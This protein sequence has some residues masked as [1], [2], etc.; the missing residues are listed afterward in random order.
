MQYRRARIKGGTYFFTLVTANR[1][2]LFNSETNIDLLGDSFRYV[3]QNHPFVM[4]AHVIMPDHI[5]C[6]WTLPDGD[7]DFSTRWRL[8]K[9]HF[10]RHFKKYGG[11]QSPWQKKFWEHCIRDD[12]DLTNHIEYIHYNPVKHQLANMPI[13][14]PLS[15][16][17]RY[18]LLGL[19]SPDWG[20][21]APLAWSKQV[22]CE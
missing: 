20:A 10:T 22:G 11:K 19:Y 14:W 5:H 13:D 1:Q 2:K 6:I 4:D 18:I 17:H 15:S 8:I 16:I 21:L 12:Q 9:S 7:C 3:L